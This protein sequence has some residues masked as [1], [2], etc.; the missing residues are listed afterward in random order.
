MTS[1]WT[2][3]VGVQMP[4]AKLPHYATRNHFMRAMR[5]HGGRMVEI[6]TF[7]GDFANANIIHLTPDQEYYMPHRGKVR[8]GHWSGKKSAKPVHAHGRKRE[9]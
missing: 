5:K 4:D 9:V 8:D 6:G 3:G 2:Q 7:D 1:E